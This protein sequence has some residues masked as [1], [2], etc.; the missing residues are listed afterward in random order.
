MK[1]NF[2]DKLR[3]ILLNGP[4]CTGSADAREGDSTMMNGGGEGLIQQPVYCCA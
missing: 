3:S 4:V 2:Q 1:V